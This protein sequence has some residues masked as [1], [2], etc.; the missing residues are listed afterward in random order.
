MS[1]IIAD[2]LA[3]LGFDGGLPPGSTLAGFELLEETLSAVFVMAGSR[4]PETRPVQK[5]VSKE[6]VDHLQWIVPTLPV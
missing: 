5:Q 1:H 4:A 3:L 6:L 2:E